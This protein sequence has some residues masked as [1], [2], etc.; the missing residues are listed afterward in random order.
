MKYVGNVV[1]VAALSASLS[2]LSGC[3]TIVSGTSEA[4][5]VDSAPSNAVV[6]ING[7]QLGQTPVKVSL[8]RSQ[9]VATVEIYL[10]GYKREMIELKRSV[11]GWTWGNILIGGIIG[12]V[13]DASTG[14]M[15]THKIV[16][17][18]GVVEIP[19]SSKE[20]PEGVDIWINVQMKPEDSL[21]KIG[22]LTPAS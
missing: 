19:A 20:K 14:A 22:Q 1:L 8:D 21:A 4:V 5:Q 7:Q 10:P 2:I 6:K 17:T 13:V 16:P 18:P 3:A 12:L 11:N 9:K 15:Y